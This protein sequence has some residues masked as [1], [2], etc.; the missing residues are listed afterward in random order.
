MK[1]PRLADGE[2]RGEPGGILLNVPG[3]KKKAGISVM[4]AFGHAPEGSY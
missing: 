2:R 4:P 1:R 3:E